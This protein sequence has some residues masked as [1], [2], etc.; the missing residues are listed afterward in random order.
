MN[1]IYRTEA[2]LLCLGC[3]STGD[4]PGQTHINKTEANGDDAHP[5]IL[6]TWMEFK[7]LHKQQISHIQ[8]N[9]ETNLNL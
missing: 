9:T 1:Y 7:T 5:N 8:S 4:L 6:A 2:I 3:T